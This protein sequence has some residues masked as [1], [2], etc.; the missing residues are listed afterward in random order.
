MRSQRTVGRE[1]CVADS[2][3]ADGCVTGTCRRLRPSGLDA[4]RE[5]LQRYSRLASDDSVGGSTI[6]IDHHDDLTCRTS[7]CSAFPSRRSTTGAIVDALDASARRIDRRV[8]A[9]ERQIDL[10][11]EHRQALITAAVTGELEIPG[12]AA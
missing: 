4:I 3:I 6:G 7:S 1:R 10:L 8:Q 2:A 5:F 12:V 9:L 11:V